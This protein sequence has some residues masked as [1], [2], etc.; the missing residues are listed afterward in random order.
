MSCG[1]VFGSKHW[2]LQQLLEEERS[3]HAEAENQ[4]KEERRKL[5]DAAA[6]A[7]LKAKED[8]QMAPKSEVRLADKLIISY[9][10]LL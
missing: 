10:T 9:G 5:T 7:H 2:Q 8:R 3:R 6:S 1:F 4:W